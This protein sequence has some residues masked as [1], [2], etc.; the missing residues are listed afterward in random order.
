[1]MEAFTANFTYIRLHGH[2]ELYRGLYGR[3]RLEKWLNLVRAS[4]MEAF[5]YFD[6]TDDGSAVRDALTFLAMIREDP[7]RQ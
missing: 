4:E 1:M 6:N 5:V 3:Q 2:S 7:V